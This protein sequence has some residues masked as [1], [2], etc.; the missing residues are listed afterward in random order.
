[1]RV[2]TNFAKGAAEGGLTL[3][4]TTLTSADL[5]TFPAVT[6][7]DHAVIT[8]DPLG[9]GGAPEIVYVTAHTAAA[10][11]ATVLRGREGTTARAHAAETPW[12]HGP[13]G[14]DFGAPMRDRPRMR[15]AET[16]MDVNSV[17]L[18]TEAPVARAEDDEFDDGV[19]DPVWI[20]TDYRTLDVRYIESGNVLSVRHDTQERAN[21]LI[22]DINALLKPGTLAVGE[23]IETCVSYGGTFSTV[24]FG[25]MLSDGVTRGSGSQVMATYD[26]STGAAPY[27]AVGH[28]S[29]TGFTTAGTG[30]SMT[31]VSMAMGRMFLRLRLTTA[32]SVRYSYSGDGIQWVDLGTGNRTIA[33]TPTHMGLCFSAGSW[34]QFTLTFEYF[35]IAAFRAVGEYP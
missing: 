28:S 9:D 14:A 5:A 2:R 4:G 10:T 33:F 35:R 16:V 29:H 23:A 20:R 21:P 12:V 17:V 32:T 34:A 24:R 13:T 27:R 7:A 18:R 11:T 6:G 1:M 26:L 25:L 31:N 19:L 3:A 8:V 15:S 22:T 30:A